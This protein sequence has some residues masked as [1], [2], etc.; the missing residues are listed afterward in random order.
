MSARVSTRLTC[1]AACF[2]A[3]RCTAPHSP[4]KDSSFNVAASSP[5]GESPADESPPRPVQVELFECEIVEPIAFEETLPD[6]RTVE[7]RSARGVTEVR[8]YLRLRN[9]TNRQLV[10]STWNGALVIIPR[11]TPELFCA[12]PQSADWQSLPPGGTILVYPTVDRPIPANGIFSQSL[13][14]GL[15]EAPDP[16]WSPYTPKSVSFELTPAGC[17]P[18]DARQ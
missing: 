6:G 17:R 7:S 13:S 8:L 5:D 4:V 15:G 14:L 18:L 3:L 1:I 11:C 9:P 16:S 12:P 10:A 2:A